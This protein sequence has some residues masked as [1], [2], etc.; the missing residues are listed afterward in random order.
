MTPF[1]QLLDR[2]AIRER[3]RQVFPPGT[4]NRS[5]CIW[6]ISARTIFVMVYA[7]AV[8]GRNVWVRPD[9]VTRMIDQ[10]ASMTDDVSRKEWLKASLKPSKGGIPDRWYAANTRESIRDDTIRNALI[11]NGAVVERTGLATTSP[12]PRYAL[13]TDF[14]ALLRPSLADKNLAT[15]I[16]KWQSANLGA[17]ARARIA[18]WRSTRVDGGSRIL[19]RFPNGEARHMDPG[20]SS[21]IAKSVIEDFSQRFLGK[22][23][24]LWLSES[25]KK[26]VARDDELARGIGLRTRPN[27][28]LPDIILVDLAPEQPAIVFVEV[29]ATSGAVSSE[30]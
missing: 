3:L 6:E 14:S 13:A 11:P 7:G 8:E 4:P 27:R 25:R 15:A 9:Q 19:V 10:Q 2:N 18:I 24:V 17:S 28:N 29:V 20:Q 5:H 30:R 12:A 1:P 21:H 22:P 16:D 23:A 26:V